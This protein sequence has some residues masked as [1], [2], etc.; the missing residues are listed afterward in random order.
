MGDLWCSDARLMG[1]LA[2][3]V[4]GCGVVWCGEVW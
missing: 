1:G 4:C 2:A 3:A